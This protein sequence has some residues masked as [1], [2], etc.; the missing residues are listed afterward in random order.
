MVRMGDR[1]WNLCE[2]CKMLRTL[3][4]LLGQ[5]SL[6]STWKE[7]KKMIKDDPRYSKFSSSDRVSAVLSPGTTNPF[8]PLFSSLFPHNFKVEF[9]HAHKHTYTHT[10]PH[11]NLS[12]GRN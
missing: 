9:C 5:I 8:T 6:T 12:E 11:A 2:Y 3:L 4:G 7:V 10:C 1:A